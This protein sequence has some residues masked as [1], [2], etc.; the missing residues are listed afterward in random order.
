MQA[1]IGLANIYQKI[2][3]RRKLCII[4]SLPEKNRGYINKKPLPCGKGKNS[5]QLFNLSVN[6]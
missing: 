1:K 4:S 6:S 5:Q 2:I 3:K